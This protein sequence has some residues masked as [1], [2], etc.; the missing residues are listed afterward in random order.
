MV[1]LESQ[2]KLLCCAHCT[3]KRH[4]AA[5]KIN[6][7]QRVTTTAY[8]GKRGQLATKPLLPEPSPW[9]GEWTRWVPSNHP[10]IKECGRTAYDRLHR[11]T[12]ED[13]MSQWRHKNKWKKICGPAWTFTKH[14]KIEQ[15][16]GGPPKSTRELRDG[17]AFGKSRCTYLLRK[18][19]SQTHGH[20]RTE[21]KTKQ[22]KLNDKELLHHSPVDLVPARLWCTALQLSFWGSTDFTYLLLH[23]PTRGSCTQCHSYC[24]ALH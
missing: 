3:A 13:Q 10:E 17:L 12:S 6:T 5:F 1:N 7:D 24:K 22:I 14:E 11:H 18:D 9:C 4:N 16:H 23:Q 8:R 20:K 21:R 15:K 2:A 19:N